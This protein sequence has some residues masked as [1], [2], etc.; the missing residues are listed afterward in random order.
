MPTNNTNYS[1]F[2]DGSIVGNK[3]YG[4]CDYSIVMKANLLHGRR[5]RDAHG[6]HGVFVSFAVPRDA[7]CRVGVDPADHSVIQFHLENCVKDSFAAISAMHDEMRRQGLQHSLARDNAI[8]H[9][10][11]SISRETMTHNQPYIVNYEI[12][13]EID[14][15]TTFFW[16]ADRFSNEPYKNVCGTALFKRQ[17]EHSPFAF[18]EF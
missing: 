6:F 4:E 9:A 12:D 13:E 15:E 1:L 3:N 14:P 5:W 10:M 18:V 17:P 11:E 8:R 2:R 16:C 7:K